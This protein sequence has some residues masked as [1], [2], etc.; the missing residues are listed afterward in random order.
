[1]KKII[2]LFNCGK[3]DKGVVKRTLKETTKSVD[4]SMHKC[5]DCKYY[6][7]LKEVNS[8]TIIPSLA[9]E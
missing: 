5:S 4:I 2:E 1:M 8:L 9:T 6:Y 3:C 7:G